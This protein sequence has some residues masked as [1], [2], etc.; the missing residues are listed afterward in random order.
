MFPTLLTCEPLVA[1]LAADAEASPINYFLKADTM[2]MAK[3]MPT[4]AMVTTSNGFMLPLVSPKLLPEVV[5][6]TLEDAGILFFPSQKD[7]RDNRNDRNDS[8]NPIRRGRRLCLR[9]LG[10]TGQNYLCRAHSLIFSG[11]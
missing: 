3:M 10:L 8:G 11:P 1:E 6:P 7:H 2:M 5:G 9:R 4:T